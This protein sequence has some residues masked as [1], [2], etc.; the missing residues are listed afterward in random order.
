MGVQYCGSWNR[1]LPNDKLR[2]SSVNFHLKVPRAS[3]TRSNLG[4]HRPGAGVVLFFPFYSY[5]P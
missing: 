4:T 2:P 5:P 3:I 1:L